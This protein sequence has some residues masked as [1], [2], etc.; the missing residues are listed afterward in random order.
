M[1]SKN[2]NSSPNTADIPY[3]SAALLATVLMTSTS[4]KYYFCYDRHI[5]SAF[6]H[7]EITA[8]RTVVAVTF[9]SQMKSITD[10][11]RLL[12]TVILVPLTNVREPQHTSRSLPNVKP[13]VSSSHKKRGPRLGLTMQ[14]RDKVQQLRLYKRK[15]IGHW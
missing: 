3:E 7:L 4:E 10:H 15:M 13:L 12:Q 2:D 8:K 14:C 5:H 6:K 9:S 1:D 11:I